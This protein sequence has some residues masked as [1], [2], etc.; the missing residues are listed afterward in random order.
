ML[1]VSPEYA[2]V[3]SH[4]FS[5]DFWG[6]QA[7]PVTSGGRGGAWFIDAQP[8]DLVLR[9]YRRGGLMARL[10]E[11]TYL[12]TGFGHARSLAEF[13]LL[14]RLMSAGLPVPEPVA[15]IAWKY[16]AL[17]YQAAILI[18]RIPGAVTLPDSSSLGSEE[19]WQKLGQVV[20]RFHEYGLDH[21]DLNCD[22]I[23]VAGDQLYL[24]DFDRCRVV[25]RNTSDAG[26]AWK[27]RNLDRLHRS[28]EKRCAGLD[29]HQ[30]RVYWE[31]FL[32]AY[33]QPQDQP[34][35]NLK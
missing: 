29:P 34:G 30:R 32:Q 18:K 19:L 16:R 21:V 2:G 3:T 9:H 13:R 31:T 15:A 10:A 14:G 12:F 27:R 35:L 24:I 23:L 6:E 1:L 11:K 25:D 28:V 17:W 26:S 5:P 22:N 8:D 7:V 4:W 33:G 20:R